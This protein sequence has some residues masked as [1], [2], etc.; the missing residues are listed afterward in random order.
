M[1]LTCII[2]DDEPLARQ[3]LELLIKEIDFLDLKGQFSNAIK[4]N[5][6][7]S[8]ETVDLIF[9]DIQMPGLTGLE[10]AASLKSDSFIVFTTAYPQY[11]LEGFELN[12]LDY[13]VK[14]IRPNR[15]LQTIN[16][17]KELFD[18]YQK[19]EVSE[20]TISNEFIYVKSSRTYV[21][22]FLKDILYIQGMKD[23]V[24][25][26][27]KTDKVMTAMNVKTIYDQ[28]PQDVFARISKSHIINVNYIDQVEQECIQI[29][30]NT[31]PLGK[32]YKEAFITKFIK[33]NLIKR[34]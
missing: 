25:L 3:G 19:S 22:I 29:A 24:M 7:L 23:Y 34:K 12:A 21:R 31:L 17:A 4:A 14:P 30:D 2:I 28:L 20:T 27:T 10:F 11:A 33:G 5:N 6:F 13:L 32:S 16:K 15:F 18:I 26:F 8:T 1:K 9:L